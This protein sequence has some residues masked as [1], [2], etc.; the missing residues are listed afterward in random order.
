MSGHSK[1]NNIKRRK[2]KTDGQKAKIFTKIGREI[3]V[4]VREGGADPASNGRLRDVIAKAKSFNVPND[5][6]NRLIQKA[7]SEGKSNYEAVVYEGYGPGGL[8]ALVETLTDNRN[9]TAANLRHYFDKYGAGLGT[10]GCTA[11]LFDQKGIFLLSI[12]DKNPETVE[13]LLFNSPIE[14]FIIDGTDVKAICAPEDFFKARDFFENNGIKIIDA[15]LS[16]LAKTS[17]CITEE[18]D[19][20]RLGLL[21]SSLE[22]DDDVQN[23]YTNLDESEM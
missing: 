1:W 12:A 20:K 23:V 19:N 4:I 9:R 11:Y 18:N 22:D 13:E 17:V 8:A 5:N 3:Q 21:L 7:S 14:D 2:E 10:S 16:Y 6:I 15:E